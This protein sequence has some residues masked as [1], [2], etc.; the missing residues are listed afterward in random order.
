MKRNSETNM[1]LEGLGIVVRDILYLALGAY[2]F[3]LAT[4]TLLFCR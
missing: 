3:F 4:D 1:L 2:G